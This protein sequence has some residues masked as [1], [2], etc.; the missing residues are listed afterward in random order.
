VS[1]LIG[2]RRLGWV[3]ALSLMGS[4]VACGRPD[5]VIESGPPRVDLAQTGVPGGSLRLGP[6]TLRNRGTR[7]TAAYGR[8]T[9]AYFLSPDAT[10]TAED[11]RLVG[12]ETP[13][14]GDLGPGESRTF[15]GDPH[16]AIP[17]DVTPGT[18]YVGILVD[19]DNQ[20]PESDETNNYVS[21]RIGIVPKM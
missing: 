21:V 5:L 15:A 2:R 18:Y 3:G 1:V 19:V 17:D 16:I 12:Q 10:I 13:Q 8:F 11:R 6:W 20:V 7:S 9:T 14:V 4:C